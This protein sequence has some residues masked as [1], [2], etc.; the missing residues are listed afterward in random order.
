MDTERDYHRKRKRP[1]H[2]ESGD[3]EDGA[4]EVNPDDPAI[5]LDAFCALLRE[6]ADADG[7]GSF[8]FATRV[9]CGSVAPPSMDL[10]ERAR[11]MANLVGRETLW[12]WT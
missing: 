1:Q 8:A 3:E 11:E 6:S 4:W 7:C 9:D 5:S 2:A 12:R 10:L